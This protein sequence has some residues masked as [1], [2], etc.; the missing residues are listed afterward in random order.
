LKVEAKAYPNKLDVE[1]ER[2]ESQITL[3][4]L[5]KATTRTKPLIEITV[6]AEVTS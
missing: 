2:E 5:V 3:R 6:P 4:F 1:Y